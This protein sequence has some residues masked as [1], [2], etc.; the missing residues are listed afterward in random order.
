MLLIGLAL[1]A[2]IAT[3]VSVALRHKP[4]IRLTPVKI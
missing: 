4:P 3:V 1:I 2:L